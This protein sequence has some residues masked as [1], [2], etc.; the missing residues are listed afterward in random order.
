MASSSD[1][2][3]TYSITTQRSS[4]SSALMSKRATR[5]GCFEVQAMP[6][7]AEFDIEISPD[8]LQGDLFAGVAR[9][10]VDFAES[11]T[12]D[13]TLDRISVKRR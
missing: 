2:P 1:S 13:A 6:D 8:E 9:A 7:T 3:E 4:T 10:V 5:F 12:T 11:T